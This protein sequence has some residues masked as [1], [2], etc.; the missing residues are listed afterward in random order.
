MSNVPTNLIPTKITGLPEYL[1]SSTLGYLP[2]VLEGRTYKVQFGQ[3]AA[4]GAVPSTRVIAAGTGLTGGG[5]LSQDRVISIANGGVGTAQ[6][7]DSGV[8]AGSYGSGTDVPVLTVDATGRITAASTTPLSISGYVPTSRTITTGAGLLGGG[9]LASNLTLTVDFSS[10]TPQALGSATAGVSTAA[11][12]GDH[13][14]PAVNLSDTNQ[15]QGALPL[16]RGGTG[17]ALSPVAG[18]VVYSTGTKLA[19]ADPGLPGQVL[20]S[21]G[22][23]EPYWQTIAGTGTVTDVSVVTANG[24]AG[25]VA[26][27]STTP[28]ITVSTTVT[29]VVKG[30]GTALS[31]AV[32]GTDYVAPGAITGSGLT[33]ATSR[34]LGRT[35]ASSGAIE[36]ITVGT[37]LSLSG[38]SLVN[39]AP[40]QVV[41][42]TGGTAISISGSYPS[43]TITNT[44]PDQIVSLTGAG[45]TVVTGT[46]PNFTITSNDQY[47]GTVTS[48]AAS[49]GTTG[50]SF[51]GSPIT[52]SGTLT[53]GG[54]LIVANGGT[55]ATTAAG[56]RTNLGAAASGANSDITSLSGITG[57]IATPD[58][59]DF[60]T[61]ATVTRATGRLWWDSADGIQTLNLG[62]AGSNA[63]M[64][65]GEEMYFRVKASSAITEG[66]VVMFTG[67]VGGSG[68]LTAAPATGLTKDTASYIMGVATEDIALNGWGYVTQF[69]LVRGI[70]TTGGAEAWVDGQILYYNPAVAGGLTKNVPSAPNAKVEVAAV[71]NAASGGSGSLFVRPIA[72]FSL[73][74]LNDVETAAATNLDLLQYNSSGGYWQHVSPSTI[75]VGTATN[76]AGGAANRIAYQTGS[77]TT[78]FITAPSV[79]NTFLE[80]S[81]SAFQWSSNPL[82]TVTS[83]AMTVPTG[84]TVSGS[85]ITTSGTLAVS[86]QSGYS[87]PTTASQA[88]WDTAYSERLQWDG[89]STNLVAATGRTSLGATTVGSNFFTLTNPNAITF[90]QINADNTVSALSAA[91]F[92]AA[93]GAGTGSGS[94]TSVDVSGGT[95]GLTT[96]GGPVT[97]SGTI[98]LA[99]T[100]NVANGG[101]GATSLTSGYVLKG[102]GTSAV[103]SSIIYDNG[104]NVGIGTASPAQKLDVNGDAQIN[105][106]RVGRGAGN[107][108]N[109][110]VLGYQ[111]LNSNTTGGFNAA[112]G[113]QTL[114]SNTTGQF[115]TAC[116][117]QTLWSNTTGTANNGYG[118]SALFATTTGSFN[119]ANGNSALRANTT[120]SFNTA[121]GR[122]ALRFSSVGNNNTAAGAGALQQSTTSD[123]TAIGYFAGNDQTSGSRNTYIGANTGRGIVTGSDNTIIGANVTGLAAGLSNTVIIADSAGNIRQYINSSGN[124]GIGDTAPAYKLTV[125]GDMRLTGGGDL[126][127]G[128]ATGTTTAGGDS[129]IY[130]D[131]NNMIFATGTTTAE[132]MRID[133]SGNLGIGESAPTAR[134][135]VKGGTTWLQNF[136][137]SASSPTETVDW[138]VPALNVTSYGDFTLQTMMTFT[139]PNDGNY[140]TGDNVWNFRLDQTA[141]STT[142]SGVNGMR[143]MG[144]GYLMFGPGTTE[145][146]RI[147]SD[148]NL[149]VGTTSTGTSNSNSLTLEPGNGYAVVNHSGTASGAAYAVFGYNGSS[150]GSITQNGTTGVL[151]NIVSDARLKHDIVDA[152]EASGLIDAIKVRSFKWNADNSEQRYGVIAQELAEV[153][154]E[155]VSQP[156]DPEEMMGVDYSKL[157]PLLIKEVQSLRAR[158]A[159]LEGK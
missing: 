86:L 105:N 5:D 122:D 132:R 8:I 138:P 107:S 46:Y 2:Y 142:S 27:P 15:T 59:I 54:T 79:A 62:M 22:A 78:G 121:L 25:T 149:L 84:L 109:S 26:D 147:T 30:D 17:D 99:G 65:I 41:T 16:G 80:W 39:S 130:N 7:A 70:D 137:G 151:Y 115:N 67:T 42:L 10:A 93:I 158:V 98:T 114:F 125:A 43:F 53:L 139:L 153:A 111:A 146:A 71:V 83:V 19:L 55:G 37:G 141:S 157:V 144:P 31:A 136:S 47:A 150:I 134:L 72:R 35:T 60:D 90:P 120:G 3:L 145:K 112:L 128:S 106:L 1:G 117:F 34:L 45:T 101:T 73:G 52:T 56:A 29:G 131:A 155:A 44:A 14:H 50:L 63:T 140:F 126:R 159:Q 123:N 129:Q 133:S 96:S 108:V 58:Y 23:G 74:Q 92:R 13:V 40:D 97:T 21:D 102:N 156:A 88:N 69:G 113:Y 12:R 20:T 104:T 49:G 135:H 9:S 116:G 6:L 94:V 76:L 124:V 103:S 4:V 51:T 85:P 48:V 118:N 91:A 143:F 11:A 95:T 82:G 33:M 77:G 119:T 24:F 66:Q 28:E 89:G 152:P 57:G 18:A 87:I 110:A 127:L 75:S 154:P 81:G 61:A 38:G 64:Q 36:E 32:A 148:G 68:A 100:L